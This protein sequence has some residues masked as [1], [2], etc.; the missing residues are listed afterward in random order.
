M[1]QNFFQDQEFSQVSVLQ[2][3]T[4]SN[5]LFKNADLSN[6][7]F[8]ACAFVDCLFESCN[9]SNAT[10][11][12]T[13][14]RSVR[15]NGCKILGVQFSQCDTFLLDLAFERCQLDLCSFYKLKLK[16]I[17]FV[18]CSLRETDFT[19]ADLSEARFDEC[20]LMMALFDGTVLQKADLRTA[21]NYTIRPDK[22]QI[23]KAK[24]S[25]SGL[26]GLLS[27]FDIIISP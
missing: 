18:K 17:R 16:K 15:F 24:F 14:L 6:A 4:Y 12:R 3:G 27:D 8:S 19:G 9:L 11:A 13:A 7:V 23:R 21:F 5:C 2:P 26:E 20:D 10:L 1:S 25:R 22:N